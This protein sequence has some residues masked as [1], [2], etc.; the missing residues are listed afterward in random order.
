[1]DSVNFKIGLTGVWRE[2]L[3]AKEAEKDEPR[4]ALCRLLTEDHWT[5]EFLIDKDIILHLS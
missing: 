5:T 1:M 3:L 4:K 2:R